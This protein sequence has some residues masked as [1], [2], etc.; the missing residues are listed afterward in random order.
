MRLVSR[1]KALLLRQKPLCDDDIMMCYMDAARHM[2]PTPLF[3]RDFARLVEARH[4]IVAS[5][6][7]R[8]YDYVAGREK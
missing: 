1:I 2:K 8:E 3:A 4:G 6:S 5:H 7:V